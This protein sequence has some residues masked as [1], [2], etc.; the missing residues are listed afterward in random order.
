MFEWLFHICVSLEKIEYIKGLI[1]SCKLKKDRQ[2]KNQKTDR[3]YNNQKK[4]RQYNNQKTDRQYN[5]QK[6]RHKQSTKYYTV[7][8]KI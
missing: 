1:R 6:K 2:Y 5:N 7:K 4:D 8:L 3:Q